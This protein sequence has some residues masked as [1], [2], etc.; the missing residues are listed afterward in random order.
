MVWSFCCQSCSWPF[1]GLVLSFVSDCKPTDFAISAHWPFTCYFLDFFFQSVGMFSSPCYSFY[2]TYHMGWNVVFSWYVCY[3]K[4]QK[5]FNSSWTLY[6]AQGI[7]FFCFVLSCHTHAIFLVVIFQIVSH[8]FAT[9]IYFVLIQSLLYFCS[10]S[11]FHFNNCYFLSLIS[12][13]TFSIK[14]SMLSHIIFSKYIMHTFLLQWVCQ[15]I[16]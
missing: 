16:C 4:W 8:W 15:L 6:S 13:N 9:F 14:E 12:R 2:F 10:E 7:S 5:I 1:C 11:L 3:H